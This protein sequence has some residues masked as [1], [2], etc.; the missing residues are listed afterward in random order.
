MG[1]TLPNK[2]KYAHFLVSTFGRYSMLWLARLLDQQPAHD[3]WT[4][5]LSKT[6]QRPSI[7]WEE[8]KS[9]VNTTDGYLILDDTVID[10]WYARQIDLVK[11]Q[12]SGTH[13][14][15]V[16][17]IDVVSL[18]WTQHSQPDQAEHITVDF[19]IYAP[20]Y[21]G[22]DKNDHAR[23]MLE[24]AFYRGFTNQTV[25]MDSWYEDTKTLKL[26]TGCKWKFI[27]GIHSNRQVKVKPDDPYR[28]VADVATRQGVIC[29]MKKYGRVKV[30]KLVTHRRSSEH[31]EYLATN[32][33]SLTA[34]DVAKANACRW[35]V[36]EYHRGA[37]QL[38]GLANC[39]FQHQRAQRNHLL[40]SIRA[41][42]ALE[43]WRLDRGIPW[44]E[45]K[46]QLIAEAIANYLKHPFIP[47][48]G[49]ST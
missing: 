24:S 47:L 14:R 4:R 26:I 42:L 13:H 23:E 29:W 44:Y 20:I 2:D 43:Q 28:Q 31:I 17:G 3:S 37:K 25:L 21:D 33:L 27:A 15:K 41:L 16:N 7:L 45:A 38:T 9:L 36:E 35:Q 30:F 1:E 49:V 32:D 11:Y 18:L 6:K 34:P 19:R 5:W 12:Y 10:K 39:Q 46:Q 40:C 8:V 22:Y 48:P